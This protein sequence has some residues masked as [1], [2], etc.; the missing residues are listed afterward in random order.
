M[1]GSL[2]VTYS[3]LRPAM[4]L[5]R[6][7]LADLPDAT[8]GEP[9]CARDGPVARLSLVQHPEHRSSAIQLGG[10]LLPGPL[11]SSDLRPHGATSA[12]GISDRGDWDATPVL[13][14]PARDASRINVRA[15]LS[16][17]SIRERCT[18]MP[19]SSPKMDKA[20]SRSIR[21]TGRTLWRPLRGG[22]LH[23]IQPPRVVGRKS[24][25]TRG[26]ARLT[27]L[28]GTIRAVKRSHR[29]PTRRAAIPHHARRK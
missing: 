5:V 10:L 24:I 28:G 11:C 7:V 4:E 8:R 6:V 29:R 25:A 27:A 15:P 21:C 23:E 17:T 18:R 26:P 1:K 3:D 19:G 20:T 2:P 13:H 14:R 12:S 9:G 22:V 16:C